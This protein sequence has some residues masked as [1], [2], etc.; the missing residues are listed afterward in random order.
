MS[1]IIGDI[2]GKRALYEALT[3]YNYFPN[4]RA[5]VGELPPSITTRQYTPEIAEE[6][7][8][9]A[10]VGDR[11]GGG[12]DLVEYKATRY[13]NVPRVLG[14]IHPK[15]YAL[16]AKCIHDNWNVLQSV[17]GNE[18][19][20]VKPELHEEDKRLM[21]MN[22]E[23]PMAKVS[24]SHQKGFAKRFR[25]QADIANCF[26]SI[27]SHAIP[28][29][30]VGIPQAKTQKNDRQA[31]FNQLDMYQRKTKRNE[32]Q[33]IPIGSATSSVVVELILGC[34]DK[35]LNDKGYE[36]YR[37]IDDY[38]C[39]CDSDEEAQRFLQDLGDEL[40]TYKL[41]LNLKKTIIE[42]LPS[43][44]EDTWVLELR[45]ALPS[46]LQN[47]GENEPKLTATEVLTF[48]N[49][50][51]EVNKLTPDGSVLKY[52]VSLVMSHLDE[53]AAPWLIEPLL[54]LAWHFPVLLPL[55]DLILTNEQIDPAIYRTQLIEIIRVNADKRRSDGMAWP[56]HSLLRAGSIVEDELADK[57]IASKDCVSI[58]LLLEMG[59]HEQKV[60]AF[61]NSWLQ[62]ASDY[63]K[64]NYWL[65]LYQLY[66]KELI[67][68]PYGDG[69]FDI[70]KNNNVNFLPGERISAA[71][72]RCTEIQQEMSS[73][74]IRN[75]FS[76]VPPAAVDTVEQSS[77]E[78]PEF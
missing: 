21:V 13:N 63:D 17:T 41:T 39:Y 34:V 54:N 33:G 20:I 64:D 15:S 32:T 71:E 8:A 75:I 44:V 69:V 74:A 30:A 35:I 2:D 53:H 22:Y 76:P 45:G 36:F 66:F 68:E 58:C 12:Y 60:V 4:Q 5:N 65:L 10:D 23:E 29:A 27:Y 47:A 61:V 50:A 16:L 37:Y 59:V 19:S 52:A 7:A 42:D 31:W 6:L 43:A 1:R 62:L 24:R 67:Q 57:V 26:N 38:T 70:L 49:R 11:R 51:I 78:S 73:Q 46:R 55:L 18:N 48:I 56:L 72:N 3:R 77:E 40:A 9:V 25:V 28:W 14:L